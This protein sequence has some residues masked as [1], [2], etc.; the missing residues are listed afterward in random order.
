M[1]SWKPGRRTRSCNSG[2]SCAGRTPWPENRLVQRNPRRSQVR[3]T[4][5]QVCPW[6]RSCRRPW[7]AGRSCTALLWALP[8]E[9][10][11][12]EVPQYLEPQPCS[13]D[14]ALVSETEGLGTYLS[15]PECLEE[16]LKNCR[17]VEDLQPRKGSSLLPPLSSFLC[18]SACPWRAPWQ[19]HRPLRLTIA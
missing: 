2:S 1:R 8:D 16:Q 4:C 17:L 13:T 6:A 10:A 14:S 15:L 19:R 18:P 5:P 9:S 7:T 11:K 3:R 12:T